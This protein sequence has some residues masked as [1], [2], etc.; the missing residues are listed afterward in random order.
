MAKNLNEKTSWGIFCSA[1]MLVA[2]G[3]TM[4]GSIA[5]IKPRGGL[6]DALFFLYWSFGFVGINLLYF[7]NAYKKNLLMLTSLGWSICVSSWSYFVN[8]CLT[9]EICSYGARSGATVTILCLASLTA[10][11]FFGKKE[12]NIPKKGVVAVKLISRLGMSIWVF[13]LIAMVWT[14]AFR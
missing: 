10:M 1:L 6:G 9:S 2:F 11:F 4:F 8:Q 3:F 14:Q 12:N 5:F 13:L 7:E